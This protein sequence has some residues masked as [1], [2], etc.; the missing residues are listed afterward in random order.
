[1]SDPTL[2]KD[3]SKDT[4]KEE[5]ACSFQVKSSCATIFKD[6]GSDW[7]AQDKLLTEHL[8][9][10]TYLAKCVPEE[11]F[12]TLEPPVTLLPFFEK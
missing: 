3:T 8:K 12:Q 4:S 9:C 2:Q 11:Q 7:S 1:M 10:K 5:D 6:V